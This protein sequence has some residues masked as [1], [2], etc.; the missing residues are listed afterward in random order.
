MFDQAF[1]QPT[2]K[3]V[4][5]INQGLQKYCETTFSRSVI[6]QIWI[7]KNPE[8]LLDHLKISLFQP[9]HKHQVLWFVN[10][11]HNH[12]LPERTTIIRNSFIHKNE[13]RRYKYL[14]LG[15]EG[16]HFVKGHSDSKSKYTEE[17]IIRMLRLLADTIFMV[18]QDGFPTDNRHSHGHKLF[19]SP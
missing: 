2:H 13:N 11:L 14:V 12:S 16:P 15:R 1:I 17:D 19:P 5:Y 7:L 18:F 6:N 9:F 4:T 10:P 8:K 3:M